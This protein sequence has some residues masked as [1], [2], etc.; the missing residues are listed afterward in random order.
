MT[1][2]ELLFNK[3]DKYPYPE[4]MLKVCGEIKGRAF[5]PGGKGTFDNSNNISDKRI[6][7]LGQDFDCEKNFN[8]SLVNGEEDIKKNPTWRN[9]LEFLNKELKISSKD[10]FFTN[11]I[12][13]IRK[14]DKSTG[15]SPAF[16]NKVFIKNCQ[17]FF[18]YQLE[19]QKPMAIFVLGKY[20]AEFLSAISAELKSWSKIKN[21]KTIDKQN[22]Q[23]K[24]NVVFNKDVRT[25]LVLLLHPS[26][27]KVN[28]RYRSYLDFYRQQAEVEMAK[29]ILKSNFN[30]NLI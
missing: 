16:K 12:L 11:A 18:M 25:N 2:I 7:I 30:K 28:L 21:F 13:G 14:G 27:R 10:C 3:I 24:K 6:M 23:I 26:F 15:K 1:E 4:T 8:I 5:F 20:V 9:L 19:I 22:N 29:A 17:E